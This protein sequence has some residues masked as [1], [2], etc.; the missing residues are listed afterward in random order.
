VG[1]FDDTIHLFE[2]WD[3]WWRIGLEGI[4]LVPV[5]FVG[6]RYRLHAQSQMTTAK[7]ADRARGHVVLMTRM[8]RRFLE[9]PA[10]LDRHAKPLFWDVWASLMHAR[11]QD[12][13]WRELRPATDVLRQI[14]RHGSK[15]LKGTLMATAVR[16]L[17]ARSAAALQLR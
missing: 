5:D 7:R 3:L 11:M 13:E 15:P 8:A 10:L 4:D 9:H 2:D 16:L 14:A 1:G 12:V 17:G 6:A